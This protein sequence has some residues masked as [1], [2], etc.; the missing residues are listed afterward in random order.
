[1]SPSL[2]FRS[3][4]SPADFRSR[5]VDPGRPPSTVTSL[6]LPPQKKKPTEPSSS[7]T[8]HTQH[9]TVLCFHRASVFALYVYLLS[10]VSVV[11]VRF[12]G[13]SSV[14]DSRDRVRFFGRTPTTLDRPTIPGITGQSRGRGSVYL[15]KRSRE[16]TR[17]AAV[18]I[19]Y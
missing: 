18:R 8:G 16:P 5:V 14:Y 13:S 9:R 17:R 4:H 6:T 11:F 7:S 12:P 2:K 3:F 19:I 10:S 1:M 15:R